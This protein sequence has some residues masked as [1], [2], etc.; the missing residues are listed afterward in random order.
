MMNFDSIPELIGFPCS[1]N[2]V[3]SFTNAAVSCSVRSV[4]APDQPLIEKELADHLIGTVEL[5]D[6]R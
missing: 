5:G 1:V 4:E 6:V 3:A 2:I